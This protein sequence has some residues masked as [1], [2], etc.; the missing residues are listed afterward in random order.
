MKKIDEVVGKITEEQEFRDRMK[1]ISVQTFY[2]DADTYHK[3]LMQ[4]KDTIQ[5]FFKE[6]GLVK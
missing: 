6:E 4:Y 5:A 3:S 1:S 2:Q